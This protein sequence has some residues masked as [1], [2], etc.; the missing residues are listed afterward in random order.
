VKE[1]EKREHFSKKSFLGLMG[2]QIKLRK[3]SSLFMQLFYVQF[4]VGLF[5]TIPTDV[6][7]TKRNNGIKILKQKSI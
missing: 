7:N 6:L 2:R 4:I 3:F 5:K 1:R